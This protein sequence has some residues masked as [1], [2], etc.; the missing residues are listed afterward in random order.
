MCVYSHLPSPRNPTKGTSVPVVPVAVLQAE[1]HAVAS[2]V[3]AVQ[4]V[5]TSVLV[6]GLRPQVEASA[7]KLLPRTMTLQRSRSTRSKGTGEEVD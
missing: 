2:T 5:R 1:A 6:N 4:V 7:L 3:P